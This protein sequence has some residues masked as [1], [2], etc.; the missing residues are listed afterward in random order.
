MSKTWRDHARPIIA[1]GIED[2]R[3]RG[4]DGR[5]LRAFVNERYPF[6]PREYHPYRI[7]CNELTRQLKG[8]SF[9]A[10]PKAPEPLPGQMSFLEYTP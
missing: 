8:K 4:L 7:W 1:K 2:G 9:P 3:S 5:K 6:G 10:E